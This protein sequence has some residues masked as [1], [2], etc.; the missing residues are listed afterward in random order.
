MI[1]TEDFV[2]IHLHKS[3]GTFVNKIIVN[4]FPTAKKIGYHYPL[5]MLPD[6][7]RQLPIL[8]IVRNPWE[9][10]VSYYAFQKFLWERLG[11]EK[12]KLSPQ[13]YSSL[14]ESSIDPLNGI[15]IVFEVLSNNG[16]LSFQETT[17]NLLSLGNNG[18]KLD[19]LIELMPTEL[20]NRGKYTPV[21]SEGFRGMN[22][23]R[24]DLEG[25]RNTQD[26]L[27]T[28][29]FKHMYSSNEKVFFIKTDNLRQGL[30]SFFDGIGIGI[31]TKIQEYILTAKPENVSSH[32]C[33]SKY[34]DRELEN[35]VQERD[36]VVIEK[37]GFQFNI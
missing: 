28:F 22:V 19:A 8:G 12:T 5:S 34:Y 2:F 26:G 37:F 7:F 15:D 36:A 30:I 9:F 25:I 10:Y 24:K 27:Y 4:L 18:E 21:Q 29:L 16:T 23:T 14:I 6:E 20:G 31:D 1:V 3:G 11:A 35:L 17:K 32:D 13:E 33:Y